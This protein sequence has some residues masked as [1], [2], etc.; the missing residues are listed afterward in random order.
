MRFPRFDERGPLT[1]T[2]LEALRSLNAAFLTARYEWQSAVTLWDR[3][4][5][6]GDVAELH[7]TPATFPFYGQAV[8]EIASGA[9]AYERHTALVAWRYT[10]AAVVLGVTV[11]QRVAEAKPPWRPRWWRSCARSRPWAACARRCRCRWPTSCPSARTTAPS[12]TS[13]RTPRAGGPRCATVWTV[14]WTWSWRSPQTRTR[15]TPDQDEA[16]GCL[17]TEHCP[18][19]PTRCTRASW[20]RCSGWRRNPVRPHADPR[21]GLSAQTCGGAA[22]GSSPAKSHHSWMVHTTSLERSVDIRSHTSSP[23][24][25][26]ATSTC[27]SSHVPSAYIHPMPSGQVRIAAV[28]LSAAA[29]RQRRPWVSALPPVPARSPPPQAPASVARCDNPPSRITLPDPSQ[30]RVSRCE[31]YKPHSPF[32]G[33][34]VSYEAVSL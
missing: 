10:A 23:P 18:P 32:P 20:S 6:A 17:L 24:G 29:R 27:G 3:L 21:Q 19:T 22:P 33:E 7:E 15:T 2:E 9:T 34:R 4:A 31:V 28:P 25:M 26:S 30:I 1:T 8:H 11:L 13:A 12:R 5:S 14:R 16:A